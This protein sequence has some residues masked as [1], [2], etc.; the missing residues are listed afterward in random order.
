MTEK[1][2]SR[3]EKISKAMFGRKIT[4]GDKIAKSQRKGFDRECLFC[5]KKRYVALWEE[6]VGAGKYC[7]RKCKRLDMIGKKAS[8]ETRERMSIAHKN[9]PNAGWFKKSQGKWNHHSGY[10]YKYIGSGNG[11][12]EHRYVIEKHLGRKLL[13]HEVVHHVNG[14]KTDNRID[15][16]IILS[17]TDHDSLHWNMRR[18]SA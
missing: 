16:L 7:N 12:Y 15:N 17:K 11:Q 10:V 9:K 18:E 1:E 13:D 2:I 8:K 6:K 5:G 14:I 3:R 4:W